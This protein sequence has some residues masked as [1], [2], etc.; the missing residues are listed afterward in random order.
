MSSSAFL[1]AT[2]HTLRASV[3]GLGNSNSKVSY[4]P[5]PP[6]SSAAHMYLVI[7]PTEWR[8]GPSGDIHEAIEDVYGLSLAITMRTSVIPLDRWGEEA[9]LHHSRAIELAARQLRTAM[10]EKRYVVAELA[11]QYNG[12]EPERVGTEICEPLM[13]E[14]CDL[15]YPVTADWFGGAP[16]GAL[17]HIPDGRRIDLSRQRKALE[18]TAGTPDPAEYHGLVLELKYTGGRRIQSSAITQFYVTVSFLATVDTQPPITG[19]YGGTP[20]AIIVTIQGV[21]YAPVLNNGVW[22]LPAGTVTLPIGVY[23]VV[24]EASYQGGDTIVRDQTINEITILDPNTIW[25]WTDGSQHIW[26]DGEQAAWTPG[27]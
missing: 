22:S 8:P 9:Y 11:N 24:A 7:Y 5:Q 25:T 6:A 18:H 16:E 27:A 14:R 12:L 26:T 3:P 19:T 17:P 21:N 15:A 2:L 1:R 20:D 10:H 13:F 23:D 4:D